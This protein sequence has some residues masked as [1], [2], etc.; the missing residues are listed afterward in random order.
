MSGVTSVRIPPARFGEAFVVFCC[1]LLLTCNFTK[2]YIYSSNCYDLVFHQ[3]NFR[4]WG[5]R[6]VCRK[7]SLSLRYCALSDCSLF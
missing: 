3:L 6:G 1:S 4:K 7:E 2:K 5:L